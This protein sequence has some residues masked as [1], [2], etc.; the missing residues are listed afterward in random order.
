MKYS[1]LLLASLFSY[2]VQA[3]E[4]EKQFENDHVCVSRVKIMSQGETGLHY[5][6]YPQMVIALQGGVLTRH[7]ADG[8]I[9]KVDF[10]T[11]KAVMRPSETEDKMHKT[12]NM[13][14]YPVELIIIQL[15]NEK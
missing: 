13:Q 11:H 3:M 1:L 10:P 5:D 8:S 9:T 12:V 14:S 15:K 4:Y 7:E 2:S 6:M